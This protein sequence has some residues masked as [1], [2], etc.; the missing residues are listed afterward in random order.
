MTTK[1]F[2]ADFEATFKSTVALLQSDGYLVESADKESGLIN[3]NKRIEL[4][5]KGKR[6]LLKNVRSI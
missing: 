1:Q 2:E 4:K 3:V 6:P 5:K